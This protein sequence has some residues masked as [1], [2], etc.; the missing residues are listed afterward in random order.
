MISIFLL[1]G[2]IKKCDSY[3]SFDIAKLKNAISIFVLLCGIKEYD[4]YISF[5]FAK[6]KNAMSTCSSFGRVAL[7]TAN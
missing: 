4:G 7:N 2:G 5:D 3:V 1:F 6:L